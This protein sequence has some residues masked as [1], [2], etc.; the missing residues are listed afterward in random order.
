M[1]DIFFIVFLLFFSALCL[2]EFI[3][4][5]EE[6]LLALCFFSFIFFCFNTLSDSV[7]NSF[8]DRAAKFESDLLVSYKLSKNALTTNFYNF[9]VLRGFNTKFKIVQTVVFFYFKQ[10]TSYSIFKYSSSIFLLSSSKLTE[11]MLL[12]QKLIATFQTNCT[13]NLLYPLIFK[14]TKTNL[15]LLSNSKN[16]L[17]LTNENKVINT[18]ILK[19]LS[20]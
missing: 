9:F 3:V 19:F 10:F 6:I 18:Q 2:I 16:D 11:L 13:I 17:T 20:F 12:N 15:N 7:Y 4:F 5:N 1:F 8:D 14:T